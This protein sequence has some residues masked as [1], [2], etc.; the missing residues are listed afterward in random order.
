MNIEQISEK[1]ESFRK[2]RTM[3]FIIAAGILMAVSFVMQYWYSYNDIRKEVQN[4]AESELRAKKLE[5]QKVS[6]P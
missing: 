6:Q 2:K 1:L 3:P 4:W 5:V